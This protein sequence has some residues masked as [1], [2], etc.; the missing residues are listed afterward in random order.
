ML[1]YAHVPCLKMEQ[2]WHSTQGC[3]V[4]TLTLAPLE[5]LHMYQA[6]YSCNQLCRVLAPKGSAAGTRK[7]NIPCHDYVFLRLSGEGTGQAFTGMLLVLET[8]L[9]VS[10]SKATR[11]DPMSGIR[12]GQSQK[13]FG[14]AAAAGEVELGGF[15]LLQYQRYKRGHLSYN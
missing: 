8:R 2:S 11:L 13:L 10:R 3:Q 5:R 9:A 4:D 14:H 15:M 6:R 7:I 1:L 12:S